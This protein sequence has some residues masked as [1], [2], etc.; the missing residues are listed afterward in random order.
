MK[1]KYLYREAQLSRGFKI[2]VL[3]CHLI[4]AFT[5]FLLVLLNGISAPINIKMK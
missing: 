3:D 2:R 5:T 1:L 4:P